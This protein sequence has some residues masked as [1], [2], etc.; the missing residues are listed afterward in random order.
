MQF[1]GYVDK[2]LRTTCRASNTSCHPGVN[3]IPLPWPTFIFLLLLKAAGFMSKDYATD[4]EIN[5]GQDNEN[6]AQLQL[7]S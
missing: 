3:N 2:S 5:N 4:T 6:H 1:I 7:R